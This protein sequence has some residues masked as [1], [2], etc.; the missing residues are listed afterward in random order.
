MNQP[1]LPTPPVAKRIPKQISQ[2][3]ELRIDD[4]FWLRD[5]DRADI[6]DYL[7][8][9]NAYTEAVLEPTKALQS[10]LYDEI[11]SRI[12]QTDL[13][14]PV[15]IDD[16][17]YYS[18][19]VE[20]HQYPLHCRKRNDVEEVL[21]DLNELAKGH[22]YLRLGN[23][24][25][26]E[27]HRMLAYSLDR[28]G[29]EVYV[30]YIKDLATGE[31][32]PEQIANTY[33]GLCWSNDNRAVFYVSLDEAKR[34]YQAHCHVLGTEVSEDRL[35]LEELDERFHLTLEKSRSK[36]YVFLNLDS[37]ATSEIHYLGAANANQIPKLFSE[38][39]YN[40]EYDLDHHGE[41]FY[42]RTT[43]GGRNFR[44]LTAP[45]SDPSP[46][47]WKE[48]I[49]HR[50][51]VM[52]EGIDPFEKHIVVHER[53]N[54]ILQLRIYSLASGESHV[55][56]M[57]E[58]VYTASDSSNPMFAVNYYRFQ[59][60]SLITP[61][62]IFE[63]DMNTR[64]RTLLKETPVLGP[65]DRT[66]YLTT[67]IHA[68]SHDGVR[69]P[70]SLV[71]RK[72]MKLDGS[73]PMLLYGYG[74]Y[75]ISIDP[76]FSH[77]RLSL[78][79]RGF[80]YGI[81]HIRGGADLGKLWHDDGKLEKKRNTFQDFIAC[82]SHL[83]EARYSSPNRLAIMG[84]SAGGLLVGAVINQRPDLFHAVV[85]KVPFV[86]VLNTATDP[87]LPLTVI[88]YDEWGNSN[89]KE[90]W[91]YIKS[92]SPYDNVKA[93]AYPHVLATAGLNDPR[94]SYWEPAKW[95]AK[96]RTLNT[97][98]NLLLLKTNMSAGHGGASGRYERIKET[99]FDYT[100]LLHVMGIHE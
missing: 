64:A 1:K 90:F 43:D 68:L 82:A 33:Y 55:V 53:D 74:S 98:G 83:I 21:L 72:D 80:V 52:I 22:P 84:G 60:T 19:T 88:E 40:I 39:R 27:D 95:I 26:S 70:I 17:F 62:S 45:I 9:E 28:A 48:W 24:A 58:T 23:Y 91:D 38:R 54:G 97:S 67:R 13:S 6:I 42:L 12:Q 63:Y 4:Y 49:A 100:F 31:L 25:I 8:K 5:G 44:V 75:G 81:A 79:E 73:N 11:L 85:A 3:G 47:N 2:H 92:Y 77:E 96:L 37:A 7:E 99:A 87:T 41:L 34:P 78:L 46:A 18:R 93:Q 65:Y 94:V 30:T 36:A 76:G 86:D 14:V 15:R 51:T 71:H 16:Y 32:L 61:Q 20:G 35:L 69:V 10:K 56:E 50:E 66:Q 57:P 59:Y 29:D 89:Q